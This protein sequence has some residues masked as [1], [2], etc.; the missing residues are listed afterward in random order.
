[1]PKP[2]P[3]TA[4]APEVTG[5]AEGD[6]VSEAFTPVSGNTADAG[7]AFGGAAA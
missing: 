5:S 4:A 2:A 1:M 7:A 3:R 6:A